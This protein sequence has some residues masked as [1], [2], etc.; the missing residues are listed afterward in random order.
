MFPEGFDAARIR[1]TYKDYP[2]VAEGYVLRQH[3]EPIEF[4][5]ADQDEEAAEAGGRETKGELEPARDTVPEELVERGQKAPPT[6]EELNF[7]AAQPVGP[8]DLP[9]SSLGRSMIVSQHIAGGPS[10]PH[11]RDPEAGPK[12]VQQSAKSAPQRQSQATRELSEAIDE[13]GHGTRTREGAKEAEIDSPS[14][15][16]GGLEM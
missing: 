14:P 16:D 6:Q 10:Q 12:S 4:A 5:R 2:K 3:V 1:L 7:A 13:R 15:D 9:A 11:A 8:V